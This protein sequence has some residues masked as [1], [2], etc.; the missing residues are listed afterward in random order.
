MTNKP[1][2]DGIE[3]RIGNGMVAA[4]PRVTG[5]SGHVAG[6]KGASDGMRVRAGTGGEVGPGTRVVSAEA[7]DAAN[8]NLNG[9]VIALTAQIDNI[10]TWIGLGDVARRIVASVYP[11]D[12]EGDDR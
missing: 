8:D 10:K 9:G 3:P 7:I 2:L 11:A 4:D 1:L 6:D 5:R 12:S